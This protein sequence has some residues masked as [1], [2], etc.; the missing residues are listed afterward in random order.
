MIY[1]LTG[2]PGAGKTTLALELK[3]Y[4]PKAIHIDGDD[5]RELFVNKDY[6]KAGRL[7]NIELAQNIAY[8]MHSKSL[9]V[10]VSLVS[11]YRK[12][13]EEFKSKLG[14]QIKEIY[15]HTTNI[16]GGEQFH[17]AD[18]EQPLDNYINVD[19][20]GHS[21]DECVKQILIA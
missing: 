3:D 5:M 14:D 11:P 15:V 16:R 19:T 10:I 7:K 9:D 17:V 4:L 13:R 8:F 20:T 12:Q 21:V 18:Y 1:W 2:Q 6:S